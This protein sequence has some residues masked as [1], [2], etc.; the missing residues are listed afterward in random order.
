MRRILEERG[1]NTDGFKKQELVELLKIQPDFANQKGRLE[2]MCLEAGHLAIFFPKFHCEFNWIERFWGAAKQITRREC[3]YSF[4]S[5]KERV[6]EALD[7]ISLIKMRK[8]ARKCY[9][10]MDAV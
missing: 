3:D 1:F 4:A 10:Y 6:P 5:L 2:E 7:R 9:R 8:F